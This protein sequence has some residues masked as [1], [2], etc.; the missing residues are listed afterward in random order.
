MNRL[1]AVSLAAAML[2]AAGAAL[3]ADEDTHAVHTKQMKNDDGVKDGEKMENRAETSAAPAEQAKPVDK[4]HSHRLHSKKMKSDAGA[5]DGDAMADAV[6]AQ[7]ASQA[8][9]AAASGKDTH[10]VHTKQMKNDDGV[11]DGEKMAN[12]N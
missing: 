11:K 7:P 8:P 4:K 9:A 2:G 3:A 12:P 6:P 1:I 10:A 5:K